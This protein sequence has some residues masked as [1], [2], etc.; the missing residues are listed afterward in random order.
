MIVS[1]QST[2]KR[3][4]AN[5]QPLIPATDLQSGIGVDPTASESQ[6]VLRPVYR[7]LR[8]SFAQLHALQL[9]I[10]WCARAARHVLVFGP[11]ALAALPAAVAGRY[12]A[13]WWWRWALAALAASGPAA[14]KFAQWA[15]TRRDIFPEEMCL[16]L[17]AL[18]S[19][20]PAHPAAQTLAAIEAAFGPAGAGA[21]GG[22][23]RIDPR[24][25][26]SGCIAQVAPPP[27]AYPSNR[28]VT[29]LA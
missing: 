11:L 20:A 10:G 15:A 27:A 6:S 8:W 18:H 13:D 5:A 16:R 1:D 22:T 7:L 26:G 14:V 25:I 12:P 2:W 19:D 24:P 4:H 28:A 3:A 29:A 17:S 9:F 21:G 23:L